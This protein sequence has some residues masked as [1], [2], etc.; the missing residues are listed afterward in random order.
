[1]ATS[2]KLFQKFRHVAEKGSVVA[3]AV[4]FGNPNSALSKG[5]A[6]GVLLLMGVIATVLAGIVVV[7]LTWLRRA[8]QLSNKS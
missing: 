8:R 1:M 6:A 3:C 5:V 7:G 4:C 2:A